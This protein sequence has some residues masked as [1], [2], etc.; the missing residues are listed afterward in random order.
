MPAYARCMDCDVPV[1]VTVNGT[2]SLCG[3]ASVFRQTRLWP[4][5]VK[6]KAPRRPSRYAWVRA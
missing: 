2:C 1:P 6:V 4:W 3:G 5:L